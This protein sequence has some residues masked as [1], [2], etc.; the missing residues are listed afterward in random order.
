MTAKISWHK[1]VFDQSSAIEAVDELDAIKKLIAHQLRRGF[2]ERLDTNH[3]QGA[4]VDK[5]QISA[6]I[7]LS[8]Q[9]KQFRCLIVDARIS[10]V[11]AIQRHLTNEQ[12]RRRLAK[13]F[14]YRALRLHLSDEF[15][16]L[17]VPRSNSA[18]Y[19][20]SADRKPNLAAAYQNEIERLETEAFG[21][22]HPL[23]ELSSAKLT[24]MR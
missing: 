10:I 5:A 2:A 11:L 12:Y 24:R 8:L 19:C 22:V 1:D 14:H 9:P 23:Q 21:S 18:T 17:M 15:R 16:L 7:F 13:E 20:F 3:V 4:V 6:A